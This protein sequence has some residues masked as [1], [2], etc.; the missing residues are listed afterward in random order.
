MDW[1]NRQRWGSL[2]AARAP[3]MKKTAILLEHDKLPVESL[4]MLKTQP[5]G[6]SRCTSSPVSRACSS[7]SSSS[8]S[9][10]WSCS[11][12]W[13]APSNVSRCSEDSV[14]RSCNWLSTW[15][16]KS[17]KLDS[18]P[19]SWLKAILHSLL[20]SSPDIC[21]AS[22]PHEA[23]TELSHPFYLSCHCLP[24]FPPPFH[25]TPTERTKAVLAFSPRA[26]RLLYFW[27][28]WF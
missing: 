11:S 12:S 10:W 13:R 22:C 26:A 21:R 2:N 1:A 16:R 15:S 9:A 25:T 8:W 19:D 23:I 17:W 7:V 24:I 5:P 3:R 14:T 6:P 18:S 20:G 4:R 28:P 27:D